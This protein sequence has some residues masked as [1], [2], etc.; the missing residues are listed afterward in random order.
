MKHAASYSRFYRPTTTFKNQWQ[1]RRT[2]Y[3]KNKYKIIR[4]SNHVYD[5]NNW[6]TIYDPASSPDKTEKRN[7]KM[8]SE[9]TP[10]LSGK[11]LVKL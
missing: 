6:E 3:I 7:K 10:L 9:D 1:K 4:S 5:D 8:K 11:C 2:F